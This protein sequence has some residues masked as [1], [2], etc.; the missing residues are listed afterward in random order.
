[1]T[2]TDRTT[3]GQTGRDTHA[4]ALSLDTAVNLAE[5]EVLG[6]AALDR[7]ALEYYASGANDGH[8]LRANRDDFAR[9]RLRPRMLVDVS[10]VDTRTEVLGL[11]LHSPIGVAPSAFHGL[12]HEQAEK[13]TARAAAGM[14]SVM[15][16]STFSNTPIA[17][18]GEAAS[19]RFWFQLYLLSDRE[20]SR[21][22]IQRAEASGARALV[23]TV[24]A[25]YLGR[26]EPNER[27]RF[28]LPPHLSAPNVS[29]RAELAQV[30]TDTG[31][32]LANYF[33]NLV[34]K[35]FTWNDLDWLR[36]QTKLPIV[37]KGILTAEDAV[38]AAEHGCHIWVSNHGG[39]QLDTAVSSIEALPEVADAAAGRVEIYLDGGVTRGTDVLKAVALG[40][41]AV[42]LGRA[43]LWGLAAGGEGGVRRTLELLQNEFRLAMALSGKQTVGQLGRD[44]IKR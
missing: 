34:D 12:A 10:S 5:I 40:A 41:K 36:A 21:S 9:L 8:T 37:L 44:L 7:N 42:F 11:E 26:R 3:P 1:M 35:T 27:H 31:S 39:R 18:V 14:G 17:E 20:L 28:A 23:F 22:V 16:L 24:D 2:T 29:T 30:E 38:L 4:E 6:R 25:P 43:A 13:A 33:A 32:Q 19:G 15:T